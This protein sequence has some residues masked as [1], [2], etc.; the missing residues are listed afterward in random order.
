M[1]ATGRLAATV[2]IVRNPPRNVADGNSGAFT[3]ARRVPLLN[4]HSQEPDA[5][6]R[7]PDAGRRTPDAERRRWTR[8]AGRRTRTPDIGPPTPHPHPHP[9]TTPRTRHPGTRVPWHSATC[10]SAILL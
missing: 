3:L 5:G 4:I 2:Q 8:D 7:T 9:H 1:A 6:R 10:Y